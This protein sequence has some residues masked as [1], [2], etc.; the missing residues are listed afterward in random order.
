VD[1]QVLTR[2]LM[3]GLLSTV[4]VACN[5]VATQTS[6]DLSLPGVTAV[7]FEGAPWQMAWSPD[8]S[9][10]LI[11]GYHLEEWEIAAL[12]LATEEVKTLARVDRGIDLNGLLLH[13][14][15][16]PDG[17][18]IVFVKGGP[19]SDRNALRPGLWIMDIATGDTRRLSEHGSAPIWSSSGESVFVAAVTSIDELTVSTGELV[20][21]YPVQ[22]KQGDYLAGYNLSRSSDDRSFAVQVGP[23]NE[24]GLY[25]SGHN[26]IYTMNVESGTAHLLD[27]MTGIYPTWSPNGDIAAFI[28]IREQTDSRGLYLVNADGTCITQVLDIPVTAPAW[29]HDGTRIAFAYEQRVYLLD[30]AEVAGEEAL[31]SQLACGE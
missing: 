16:S 17:R 6:R 27:T 15:W 29:S 7:R 18:R 26:L 9:Q 31:Q 19:V 2:G 24:R 8:D 10:L 23:R 12:D 30:V 22:P 4:A 13:A 3:A 25:S 5:V 28:G 14:D 11:T 21:S 1:I 20:A